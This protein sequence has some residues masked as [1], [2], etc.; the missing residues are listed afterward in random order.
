MLT[1]YAEYQD[2]TADAVEVEVW[3]YAGQ[4]FIQSWRCAGE[5]R[6]RVDHHGPLTDLAVFE[7]TRLH[8]ALF[9]VADG[10]KPLANWLIDYT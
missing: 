6:V 4:C 5:R 9:Q 3:D 10:N 8:G 1:N 7:V 2:P